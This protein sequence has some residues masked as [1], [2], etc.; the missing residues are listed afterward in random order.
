MA[1]STKR[2]SF[3]AIFVAVV[4]VVF[5]VVALMQANK[6]IDERDSLYR[7]DRDKM[8]P[9]A[10]HVHYCHLPVYASSTPP[11]MQGHSTPATCAELPTHIPP[12]P[13]PPK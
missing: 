7:W 2:W 6:A 9:W 5:G 1:D 4:A 11:D 13:P 12:P 3:V 8:R 10:V